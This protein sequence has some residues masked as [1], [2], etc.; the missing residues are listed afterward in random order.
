MGE[1]RN[2][3]I[4]DLISRNDDQ[5]K[6]IMTR[7]SKSGRPMPEKDRKKLTEWLSVRLDE[8]DA[9]VFIRQ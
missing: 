1:I 8:P 2:A 5:I 4:D 6:A 3:I 9:E 7:A